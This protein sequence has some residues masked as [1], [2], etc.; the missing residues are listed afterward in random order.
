MG[1]LLTCVPFSFA[2]KGLKMVGPNGEKEIAWFPSLTSKGSEM[3]GPLSV[4]TAL[5]SHILSYPRS[6]ATRAMHAVSRCMDI[7][8]AVW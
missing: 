2:S 1:G 4:V 6:W 7:K 3:V 5:R 8:L